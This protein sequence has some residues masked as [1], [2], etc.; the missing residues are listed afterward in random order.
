VE[1]EPEKPRQFHQR[2]Y[3]N[4][5]KIN[6]LWLQGSGKAAQ[7]QASAELAQLHWLPDIPLQSTIHPLPDSDLF[8]FQEVSCPEVREVIMAMPLSKAPGYDKVPLSVVK[9]C[10]PHILPILTDL[11]NSSFTNLYYRLPGKR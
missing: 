3:S 6:T 10:L 2:V 4:Q 8:T 7:L 11:I 9:D 1:C 5:A